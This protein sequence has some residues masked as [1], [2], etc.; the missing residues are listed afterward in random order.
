M[1]NEEKAKKLDETGVDF[2]KMTKFVLGGV[3]R[4][5]IVFYLFLFAFFPHFLQ[6]PKT[7]HL[8]G[9]NEY[10]RDS[11]KEG[12]RCSLCLHLSDPANR[13]YVPVLE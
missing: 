11:D 9:E 6:P 3:K 8:S 7:L 1:K 5:G 10:V 13:R 12:N 4:C 2:S